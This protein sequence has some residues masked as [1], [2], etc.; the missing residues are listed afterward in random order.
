MKLTTGIAVVTALALGSTAV[1]GTVYL[2][3]SNVVYGSNLNT[4][5]GA[6]YKLS[7]GNWD[8]SV[9]GGTVGTTS[10]FNGTTG[11]FISNN[12]G[13][14][15][16]LNNVAMNFSL[17]YTV[18]DGFSFTMGSYSLKWANSVASYVNN[19]TTEETSVLNGA[20]ATDNKF[21]VIDIFVRSQTNNPAHY[22]HLTNLNFTA[23]GQTL[24]GSLHDSLQGPNSAETQRIATAGDLRTFNWTLTGTMKGNEA[25]GGGAEGIK[26]EFGFKNNDLTIIPMPTPV[27]MA[28]AGMLAI[29]GLSRRRKA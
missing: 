3:S 28:A 7:S 15:S 26:V 12:L 10:P 17:S 19:P 14:A 2:N 5:G 18:G 25:T 29:A 27:S 4:V 16:A 9:S 13:G 20:A 24:V 22:M 23:A 1:A 6:K 8:Q 21:N 11:N